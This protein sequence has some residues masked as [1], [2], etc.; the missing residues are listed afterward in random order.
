MPKPSRF[1]DD[2][3]ALEMAGETEKQTGRSP[4]SPS[5]TSPADPNSVK[6]DLNNDDKPTK[7]KS[8][9]KIDQERAAELGFDRTAAFR[10]KG[11]PVFT[12]GKRFITRDGTSH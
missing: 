2:R 9:N 12:D 1:P 7:P 8:H 10:S 6:P 5:E 11:K 3:G 4:A